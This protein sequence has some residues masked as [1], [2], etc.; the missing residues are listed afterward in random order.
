[1]AQQEIDVNRGWKHDAEN[2]QVSL[3]STFATARYRLTPHVDLDAGYDNRRNVRLYRDYISPETL[4]D[5]SYRRG[6]WGGVGVRLTAQYR[7]GFSAR[8]SGGGSSGDATSYT[9]TGSANRLTPLHLSFRLRSTRY[10]NTRLDGWM[11]T[12]SGNVPV[13][14]RWL[15]E[16]YGGVREEKGRGPVMDT[17]TSWFG[18]NLDV[19]VGQNWYI[20]M[21]A[22]RNGEG[23]TAYDQVYTSVSWRF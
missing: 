17:N 14:P 1:M 20:N 16:L 11:H 8:S 2:S 12:L 9:M 13:G 18:G 10:T 4:F 7:L 3:T 15:M 23:Q 21:S 5:D 22:E 19:G 6:T